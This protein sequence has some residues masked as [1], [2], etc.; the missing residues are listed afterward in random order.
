MNFDER[1]YPLKKDCDNCMHRLVDAE[2]K[3]CRNCVNLSEWSLAMSANEYQTEALRTA[4]G[5]NKELPMLLNGVMGLCGESGE[6]IDMVKKHLFQGHKLDEAHLAK[7]LGDV[8]WYLAVTAHAIGYD[9]QTI[10][11]LNVKK[12]R[13]RYPNGFDPARS[14]HREPGDV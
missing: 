12:L 1:H 9:L 11:E 2:D 5:M 3:P 7:E 4:S 6:C 10:L 14:Q 8:A 13:D